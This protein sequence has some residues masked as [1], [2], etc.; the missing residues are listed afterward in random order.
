MCVGGDGCV[1]VPRSLCVCE[2]VCVCMRVHV[3][4]HAIQEK[5]H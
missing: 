5:V 4:S 1:G 3:C 2:C